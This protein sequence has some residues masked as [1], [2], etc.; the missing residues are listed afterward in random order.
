ME[1]GLLTLK[2]SFTDAFVRLAEVTFYPMFCFWT[3]TPHMVALFF[4]NWWI[5]V[6]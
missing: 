3:K 2:M 1:V 4:S 5:D 6:D